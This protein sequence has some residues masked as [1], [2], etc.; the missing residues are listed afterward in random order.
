MSMQPDGQS[1]VGS[2]VLRIPAIRSPN[3]VAGTSG[4]TINQ[5][6]TAE[7]NAGTFRASIEVGPNPGAHFIVY[8]PATGDVLDVYDT[9]NNLIAKIDNTGA[10][11][12]YDY[13]GVP[14]GP[15]FDHTQFGQS[16]LIF[17]SDQDL[18]MAVFE[19][20]GSGGSVSL[21]AFVE[22]QVDN[23]AAPSHIYTLQAYAGSDD[24][25]FAPTLYGSERG[26]NGSM[27]QSD[28]RS[29]DN[30]RHSDQYTCNTNASGIGTFS[31]GCSF[32]PKG[33]TFTAFAAVAA[34]A[35]QFSIQNG[36]WTSSQVTIAVKTPAGAAY[37]GAATFYADFWG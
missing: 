26:I 31:H 7:F 21:P 13:G 8:N 9:A 29:T 11:T 15:L 35:T 6:G 22:L 32:T 24:G 34:G 28:R 12:V 30:L 33:A 19:F 20:S 14:G 18:S 37:N 5:D 25:S 10:F 4:W 36:S 27:L 1:P 3:Y 17:S 23:N 2:I 16:G